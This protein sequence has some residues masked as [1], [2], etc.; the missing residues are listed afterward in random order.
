MKKAASF[1]GIIAFTAVIMYA[2]ASCENPADAPKPAAVNIAAIQGVTAPANGGTPVK[3]VT[4]NAQ[5]SGTVAWSPSHS[6]FA[7]ATQYTATI[8]LTAKSG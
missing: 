1:S 3:I 4:E 2:M 5:Y 7:A 6:T 8:T